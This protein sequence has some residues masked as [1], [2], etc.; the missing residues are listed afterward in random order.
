MSAEATAWAWARIRERGDVTP[1]AALV[2]LALADD[3]HGTDGGWVARADAQPGAVTDRQRSAALRA[4]AAAG[5][6]AGAGQGGLVRLAPAEPPPARVAERPVSRTVARKRV[7]DAEWTAAT[8]I[9]EAWNDA[10][11]QRLTVDA[12]GAM[13]VRRL[14][15]LAAQHGTRA[16]TPARHATLIRALLDGP[17][18]WD[19]PPSP[20]LIYG[21]A[22][23]LERVIALAENPPEP[24][25]TLA[26]LD[27]AK[28]DA[29]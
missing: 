2:L 4:L 12:H 3:A 5:L 26:R 27:A 15:E 25:G 11:G 1:R 14:R 19:G 9:I 7:T 8:R 10:T 18:W 28:R 21:S 16:Y 24:T 29:Q 23:Q 13:L 22:A 20:N 6:T 17:R